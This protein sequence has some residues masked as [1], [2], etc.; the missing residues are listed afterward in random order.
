[1]LLHIMRKE[2]CG[3]KDL[4]N[5]HEKTIFKWFLNLATFTNTNLQILHCTLGTLIFFLI[6]K[7]YQCTKCGKVFE[8]AARL[9][10]HVVEVHQLINNYRVRH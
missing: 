9:E 1:M 2:F 4:T 10:N 5:S 8:K 6:R 3:S 7:R